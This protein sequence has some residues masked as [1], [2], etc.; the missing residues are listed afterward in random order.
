[1]ARG[2][3]VA[4]VDGH[5]LTLAAS[6]TNVDRLTPDT[7]LAAGRLERVV[8]GI[9]L[10]VL[11]E[12][13][14]LELDDRLDRFVPGLPSEVGTLR[15]VDLATHHSGLAR[16]SRRRR[17]AERDVVQA[18]R[19]AEPRPGRFRDSDL[20]YA[21]LRTVLAR[22]SGL[23]YDELVVEEVLGPLGM[24]DSELTPAEGLRT[25]VGDLGRLVRA[26]AAPG[27]T[28]LAAALEVAAR[29]RRP[30]GSE[31]DLLALGW[32]IR[33]RPGGAVHWHPG[34]TRQT[35]ALVIADHP[36]R[37]GVA[38]VVEGR[39]TTELEHA[40]FG[41]VERIGTSAAARGKRRRT[42]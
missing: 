16:G 25:T 8:T 5:E 32:R 40:V 34:G 13:G 35:G 27:R 23:P 10:A 28:P 38:V 36:G 42:R 31:G 26:Q 18:L 7:L 15:L 19:E 39:R 30:G 6:A 14:E 41:L 20:G 29:T 9:A 33:P 21:A 1:V 11:A 22:A 12:E 17:A 2:A 37:R 3:V 24:T 4:A